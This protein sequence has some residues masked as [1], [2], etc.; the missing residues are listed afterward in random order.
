[1]RKEGRKRQ[2]RREGGRGSGRKEEGGG[3]GRVSLAVSLGVCSSRS[4]I[5]LDG[6]LASLWSKPVLSCRYESVF[7]G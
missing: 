5:E 6:N 7:Y 1:M 3:A 2:R 4:V